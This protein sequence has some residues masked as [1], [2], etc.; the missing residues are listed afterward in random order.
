VI[1]VDR[2]S[3]VATFLV[4]TST[5]RFSIGSLS[6]DGYPTLQLGAGSTVRTVRVH[7]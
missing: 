6:D 3:K 5:C 7:R 1:E 2:P 4:R